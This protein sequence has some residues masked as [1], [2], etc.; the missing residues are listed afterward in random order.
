MLLIVWLVLLAVGLYW[1]FQLKRQLEF[2]R[3]QIE[4]LAGEL[5]LRPAILDQLLNPEPLPLVCDDSPRIKKIVGRRNY[6]HRILQDLA[7]SVSPKN[8]SWVVHLRGDQQHFQLR[9]YTTKREYVAEIASLY[10]IIETE[11][12]SK[13]SLLNG[14]SVWNFEIQSPFP[15]RSSIPEAEFARVSQSGTTVE[16]GAGEDFPQ[17]TGKE[18]V[19]DTVESKT[20]E[21]AVLLD[22]E[23]EYQRI[24]RIYLQGDLDTAFRELTEFVNRYPRHERAYYAHYLIGECHFVKN[25]LPAAKEI[26]K[27]TISQEGAKLPDALLMMARI[28]RREED[29]ER[30]IHYLERLQSEYANS[31][32][33]RTAAEIM[34]AIKNE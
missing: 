4:M 11:R 2:R 3:L 14:V 12:V 28:Y 32:Y 26:F 19:G 29:T 27:E 9:G 16:N 7:T 6:W 33:S 22:P 17:S 25:N 15:E 30:A 5:G 20:I 18:N 31:R 13:F 24:A 1:C 23:D 34:E 8:T 10:G 21:A